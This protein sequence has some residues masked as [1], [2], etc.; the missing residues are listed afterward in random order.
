MGSDNEDERDVRKNGEKGNG[1]YGRQC[2][3]DS[4]PATGFTWDAS[5]VSLSSFP[6]NFAY[7][8]PPKSVILI[9][10]P[11]PSP[12]SGIPKGLRP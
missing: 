2:V 11:D 6:S 12:L 9:L 1:K 4:A 8:S 7:A 10:Y 5:S 3:T